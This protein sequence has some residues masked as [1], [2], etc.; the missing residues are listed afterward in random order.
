MS[1]L[2]EAERC[3][4]NQHAHTLNAFITPLPRAGQWLDHVKEADQRRKQGTPTIL[5]NYTL[6][7]E[8]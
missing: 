4:A 6:H 2:R 3:L 8:D 5:K 7:L 1:L